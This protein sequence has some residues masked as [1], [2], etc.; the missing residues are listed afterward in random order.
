MTLKERGIIIIKS[1]K[2]NRRKWK[3]GILH[4]L[5]KSQDGA[6]RGVRIRAGKRYLEQPTQYLDPLELNYGVSPV[7]SNI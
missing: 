5:F 3:I 4:E 7:K 1:D 6:T 2:K